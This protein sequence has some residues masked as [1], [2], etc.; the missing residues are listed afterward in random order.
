MAHPPHLKTWRCPVHLDELL[1]GV[2]ALAPA[3]RYRKVKGAP[4]ISP[5]LTRGLKNN[6]HIELDWAE[7]TDDDEVEEPNR[8]GWMDP[9]SFGRVY[10]LP[11][12][13]VILDF[14]EQ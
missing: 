1:Q 11:V 12:K 14:I 13:S 8:S 2:P 6:G 7:E 3:H 10:K 9:N 5:A 4:A